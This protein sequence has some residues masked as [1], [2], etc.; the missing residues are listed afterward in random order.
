MYSRALALRC[1]RLPSLSRAVPLFSPSERA[2]DRVA[3]KRVASVQLEWVCPTSPIL[4]SRP[5]SK[6]FR[7]QTVFVRLV[8]AMSGG[9]F[10]ACQPRRGENAP[11]VSLGA[12]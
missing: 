3:R 6:P 4:W 1:R 5:Q 11:H 2:G 8:R 7:S 9:G 10:L 12:A